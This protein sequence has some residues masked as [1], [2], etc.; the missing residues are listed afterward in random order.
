MSAESNKRIAKNTLYLYVR[1]FLTML[2]SLYT[3]RVV[4][5]VLGASDY[6]LYNV[7]GGII[8]LFSMFSG[9]LAGGT[10]RFLTFAMGENDFDKLRKVFSIS[11]GLHVAISAVL[12]LLAE[13]VGVWFLYTQLTIPDGRM[14]AAFWVYQFSVVAFIVSIVQ[15]PFISSLIAHERMDMYAYMSIYDVVM[16]LLIVFLIQWLAYDKL[17]LYGFLILVVNVT[18]ILIYNYYCRHHFKECTLRV[19]WDGNIGRR[20]LVF[21]GW[22]I[23]GS[24][25]GFFSGQGIN[26]LLNIFFGTIVNAARGIANTVNSCIVGFVSNFQTA[27]NPQIVKLYAAKEYE[28]MY[29]LVV[30]NARAAAYLY[31]FLAIP[32]FLEVD[33]ILKLW[34]GDY[35]EYTSIFVR[36]VLVQSAYQTINRPFVAM[37]HASGQMKWPNITAGISLM[38]M[39]PISYVALRFGCSPVHVYIICA[40]IWSF[41]N[42]WDLYWPHRYTGIPISMIL[43]KVYFNIIV[44][45][46]IMFT[47]PAMVAMKMQDGWLRFFCVGI[48]SVLTSAMVFYFWGMTDGMRKL[49][50]RKLKI[51]KQI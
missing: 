49:L 38:M 25:L 35:P 33:F 27:V 22:N 34:L 9:T 45:A 6:G 14:T 2:V 10:Q 21:S 41:D 12:M 51:T 42:L 11:L 13:T 23:F 39:F 29:N 40:V 3:S 5:A 20:I 18:S 44:G 15:I 8:T 26:I 47:I 24:S 17:I 37:V 19:L 46:V 50:L 32:A 31:M 28:K 30:N 16:K 36:I 7:V 48:V 43:R 1:M 4:L